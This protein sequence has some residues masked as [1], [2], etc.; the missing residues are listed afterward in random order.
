[1][2]VPAL[3]PPSAYGAP[4][5]ASAHVDIAVVQ[6]QPGQPQGGAGG[7][8]QMLASLLGPLAGQP[9]AA[10]AAPAAGAQRAGA[11]QAAAAAGEATSQVAPA[12]GGQQPQQLQQRAVRLNLVDAQGQAIPAVVPLVP[13]PG[14]G[15][16]PGGGGEGPGAPPRMPAELARTASAMLG[17]LGVNPA[18]RQQLLGQFGGI[19]QALRQSSRE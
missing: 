13:V 1:M 4:S 2:A 18:D 19:M 12:G 9:P 5:P 10:G 8:Q 16:A 14:A 17:Q 15:G 7:W 6:A 11:A 3:P